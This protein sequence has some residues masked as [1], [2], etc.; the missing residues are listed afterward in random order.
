MSRVELESLVDDV[1]R[2]VVFASA[3][4][5]LTS[6]RIGEEVM[7]TCTGLLAAAAARAGGFALDFDA[8]VPEL[9]N[10]GVPHDWWTI[11]LCFWPDAWAVTKKCKDAIDEMNK[12]YNA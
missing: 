11:D 5:E 9:N 8:L 4:G 2:S 10:S 12:K 1:E 6:K 7:R 3:G